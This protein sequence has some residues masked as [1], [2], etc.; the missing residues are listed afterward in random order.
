MKA[1]LCMSKIY[2]RLSLKAI[3]FYSKICEQTQ[4]I[5]DLTLIQLQKDTQLLGRILAEDRSLCVK[6]KGINVIKLY[7][8]AQKTSH[9]YVRNEH[10]CYDKK[11]IIYKSILQYVHQ[12]TRQTYTSR[13]S[14]NNITTQFT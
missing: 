4:I 9:L 7:K 10:S 1:D 5:R 6:Q 11:P 14:R 2:T 13:K 12:L 8:C 3:E